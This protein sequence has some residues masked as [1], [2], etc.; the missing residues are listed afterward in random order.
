MSVQ[1]DL[2]LQRTRLA[3]ER[4]LLAY[5]RTFMGFLGLG[6]ALIAVFDSTFSSALGV[7]SIA[8]G[9]FVMVIGVISHTRNRS[10]FVEE[11]REL[12]ER[13]SNR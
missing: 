9:V 6:I 11:E 10:A 7:A 13:V 8:A 2:A 1:Q 4:T 3:N 12:Q 5:V